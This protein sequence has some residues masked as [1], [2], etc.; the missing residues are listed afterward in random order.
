MNGIINKIE[1]MGLNDGPGIRTVIFFSGCKLR[2]LFCHNPET[3]KMEGISISVDEL[4]KKI[5]RFKNYYGSDGGVT[6]SGGE[7]MLQADFVIEL[8]KKLK[9]HSINIALD[10]SGVGIGKY[11]EILSLVDL[12]LLDI[13]H[14]DESEYQILTSQSMEESL[15]FIQALN[16]SN[17]PV[18][19]R[20][21]IVPG[22]NDNLNYIKDLAV[23]LKRIDNIQNVELLPYHNMAISKYKNLNIPYQW[24]N[25]E[26]MDKAVC[27]QL[28]ENL[29]KLIQKTD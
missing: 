15:K 21:V 22:Y 3:W 27:L 1:S 23:F 8:C 4:V 9:E 29:R 26:N 5:L 12:V 20:Q 13:K 2:C 11:N 25:L 14:I 28:E 6:L 10:T 24:E 7:P 16:E 18:W 19:I 17:K